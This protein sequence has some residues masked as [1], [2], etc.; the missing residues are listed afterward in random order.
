MTC[1]YCEKYSKDD[2]CPKLKGKNYDEI[3]S[4]CDNCVHNVVSKARRKLDFGFYE[5]RPNR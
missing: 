1:V 4:T 5:L 2:D 3:W